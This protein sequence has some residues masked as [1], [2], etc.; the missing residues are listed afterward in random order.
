[1]IEIIDYAVIPK[2]EFDGRKI[3]YYYRLYD[4]SENALNEGY[5][6][7]LVSG[8]LLGSWNAYIS[9]DDYENNLAKFLLKVIEKEIIDFSNEK[10]MGE[11]NLTFKYW[12]ESAP[13]I[14]FDYSTI[15]SIE[16]HRI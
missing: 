5:I 2:D 13:E 11:K 7:A 6:Y 16:G 10:I 4:E 15:H 8:S 14:D 12:T 9:N 3:R 1:M